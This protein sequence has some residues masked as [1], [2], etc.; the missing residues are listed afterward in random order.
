MNRIEKG[1]AKPMKVPTNPPDNE[2]SMASVKN[3]ARISELV[4]PTALRTPISRM[5]EFTVASMMFIMPTPLTSRVS[6]E[7]SNSTVVKVVAVLA[8]TERSWVRLYTLYTDS[9]RCRDSVY[10]VYR[11]EEHTSELQS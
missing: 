7:M 11:S 5:R 3:C 9:G 1:S 6:T 8:A 2:M 10:K 4:A